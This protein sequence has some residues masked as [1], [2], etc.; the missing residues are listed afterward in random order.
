MS[1]IR[2]TKNG[3][4]TI[5]LDG[6]KKW[7]KKIAVLKSNMFALFDIREMNLSFPTHLFLI[8]QNWRI[9]LSQPSDYKKKNAIVLSYRGPEKMRIG[10]AT[11][12]NG[13]IQRLDRLL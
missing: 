9:V 7:E 12:S 13:T 4:V 3:E 2:D 8:D 10:L 11:D 6:A 5:F 1:A